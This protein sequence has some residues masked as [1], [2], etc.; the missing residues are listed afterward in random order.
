MKMQRFAVVVAVGVIIGLT[1]ASCAPGGSSGST[2]GSAGVTYKIGFNSSATG[3]YATL[4]LPEA[5]TAEMIQEQ[6]NAAG[7]ITGPDG[8]QH[9]VEIVIYDDENEADKAVSNVTRLIQEDEVVAVVSTTGSG[10]SIA[11]IPVCQENETPC[12]SMASAEAYHYGS[13]HG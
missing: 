13:I 5:K 8:V 12:V 4:G 6:L 3:T 7:G 10:T 11:H 9:A 2:G 1:V